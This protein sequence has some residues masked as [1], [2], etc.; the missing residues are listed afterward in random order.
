MCLGCDRANGGPEKRVNETFIL[1]EALLDDWDS[2]GARPIDKKVI[3]AA[4]AVA[5]IIT[6]MPQF[7]PSSDGSIVFEWY[8]EDTDLILS[9]GPATEAGIYLRDK[10]N[11][12]ENGGP[13]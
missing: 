3:R 6:E 1:I 12:F 13:E 8:S 7:A 5:G 4:K 11:E 2:Y 9:I 10:E